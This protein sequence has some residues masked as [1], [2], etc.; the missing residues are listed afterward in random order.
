MGAM[1][2]VT[3]RSASEHGK[4]LAD[5]S[6]YADDQRL[7]TNLAWLRAHEPVAWV[8]NP[9]YRPFWAVTKYA[10]IMAIER[11]NADIVHRRADDQVRGHR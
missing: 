10:D 8:D 2:T 9:P 6:A 11:D 5:P 3:D 4:V 7:H 1:T